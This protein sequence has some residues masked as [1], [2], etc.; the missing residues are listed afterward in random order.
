M[1]D[2]K[3]DFWGDLTGAVKQLESAEKE[4]NLLYEDG[5]IRLR[6]D[7]IELID[8]TFG[9]IDEM[10]RRVMKIRNRFAKLANGKGIPQVAIET[11]V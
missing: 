3:M 1:N 7:E 8:K 9:E 10:K 2:R 4:L 6:P 11:K 5:D